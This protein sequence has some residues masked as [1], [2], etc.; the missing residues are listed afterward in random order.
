MSPMGTTELA[1]GG[2]VR[3]ESAVSESTIVTSSH[4]IGVWVRGR[5]I[6]IGGR[7]PGDTG[8]ARHSICEIPLPTD[9]P[10]KLYLF[11]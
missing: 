8:D 7:P 5:V 6:P 1:L 11:I 4:V 10:R 2:S 9:D 3:T